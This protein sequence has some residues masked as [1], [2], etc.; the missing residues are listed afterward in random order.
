MLSFSV[1]L[2]AATQTQCSWNPVSLS[3]RL[4]AGKCALLV[5]D[6]TPVI[7]AGRWSIP[8]TQPP[9]CVTTGFSEKHCVYSSSTFNDGSGISLIAKPETAAAIAG[10]IQDPMPAWRSRR[11]IARS[12]R[13]GAEPDGLPYTVI[14]VPGK[15][16]GV[17]ATR[18]IQQLETIMTSFP[19]MIADNEVFPADEDETPAKADRLFQKALDQLADNDRFTSLARSRGESGVHVVDDVIRTNAFGITVDGQ[20]MKGLYPEIAVCCHHSRVLLTSGASY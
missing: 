10:V 6:D 2:T 13:A 11:H 12:G 16:L 14:L 18:R 15:G 9:Y 19:A 8:W 7:A 4:V 1:L 17:V 3:P 20:D 5:D